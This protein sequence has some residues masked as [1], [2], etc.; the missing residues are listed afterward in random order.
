[1]GFL[2][3][4]G[5]GITRVSSSVKQDIQKAG[6]DYLAKEREKKD[7]YKKEFEAE[8]S[9]LKISNDLKKISSIKTAAREAARKKYGVT[10]MKKQRKTSTPIKRKQR[11]TLRMGIKNPQPLMRI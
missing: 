11:K 1:M 6:S 9:K 4:L 7:I 3:K 8:K 10:P 5:T 2:K